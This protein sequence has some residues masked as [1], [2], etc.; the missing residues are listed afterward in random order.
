WADPRRLELR[1]KQEAAEAWPVLGARVVRGKVRGLPGAT[2]PMV[3]RDAELDVALGSLGDVLG[4]TGG[5]L[6]VVGEAGIGKSRLGAGRRA[7][8]GA[9]GTRRASV[10]GLRGGRAAVRTAGLGPAGH[11]GHRRPPLGGRHVGAA[12]GTAARR[13]GD[14]RRAAGDR[15]AA[16]AGSSLV[17]R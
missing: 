11:P 7:P 17:G 3:G 15:P 5:I 12:D 14:G 10:A 16:G 2:A 9:A 6:F 1:G 4:G 8:P 13:R